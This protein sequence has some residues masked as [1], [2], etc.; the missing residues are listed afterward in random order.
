MFYGCRSGA[1]KI[2]VTALKHCLGVFCTDVTQH[3]K[4]QLLF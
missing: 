2:N 3:T 4:V 1:T